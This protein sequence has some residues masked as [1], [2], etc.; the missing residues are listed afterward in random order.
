MQTLFRFEKN[1]EKKS[2]KR[3]E[4]S[5]AILFTCR[6]YE[7]LAQHKEALDFL[8][9]NEKNVVDMVKK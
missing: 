8:I 4:I 3:H 9:E 2:M 6:I 7:K 5:E 1:N